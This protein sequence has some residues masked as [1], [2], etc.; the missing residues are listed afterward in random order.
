MNRLFIRQPLNDSQQYSFVSCLPLLPVP[1]DGHHVIN[2]CEM[3][4]G[5]AGIIKVAAVQTG[6]YANDER[7][8]IREAE[9]LVRS[10]AKKGARLICIPEHWLLSRVVEPENEV[11]ERFANLA[12]ESD[13]YINLGGIYEK[14]GASTYLVSPTV[15]P[16]GKIV[17]RQ[18]KVHLYRGEKKRAM[19][20]ERFGVFKVDGVNV[21]T[22]VCHDAVFPESARTAT[23]GGAEL[24]LVPS[25]IVSK[26]TRPWHIYLMSRALENR[27]PV[28][29][30]NIYHPPR[31]SGRSIIVD[32]VYDRGQ[33]VMEMR[34]VV[35]RDGRNV[36]SA[37]LDLE[38]K[39][40]LREERLGERR[41]AAYRL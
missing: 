24:L 9:T 41:P 36:V 31:V 6:F 12:I 14:E 37:E 1:K 11:Y 25:L 2:L 5:V 40:A 32:L 19:P 29:S 8:A 26:G 4:L 39:R 38:S 16:N 15:G 20:G 28:V 7:R 13:V 3:E 23:L 35:A 34:S 18:R 27:V 17:A 30:P 22:L 21:G 33:S 10:A